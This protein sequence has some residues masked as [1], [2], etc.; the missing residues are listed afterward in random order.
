MMTSKKTNA[1]EQKRQA[2]PKQVSNGRSRF[3][4]INSSSR[5]E[6]RNSFFSLIT[7]ITN[8]SSSIKQNSN[9]QPKF[10]TPTKPN[11]PPTTQTF[12]METVKNTAD[13]VADTVKGA[14]ATGSKET[15]KQVAKDSDA[16][17]GTR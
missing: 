15:N 8:T 12:K 11:N 6:I 9:Q 10:L 17:I 13:Y 2:A 16:G 5:T 14:T 7:I 1:P 3:V 4:Y